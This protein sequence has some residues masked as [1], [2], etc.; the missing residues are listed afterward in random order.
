L[1]GVLTHVQGDQLFGHT[2]GHSGR[3]VPLT[4]PALQVYI[5]EES[6]PP[7][8]EVLSPD[9]LFVHVARQACEAWAGTWAPDSGVLTG[10]AAYD[11]WQDTLRSAPAANAGKSPLRV[12]HSHA[13]RLLLAARCCLAAWLRRVPGKQRELAARWADTCD[14]VAQL[15]RPYES[16]EAVR[17]VLAQPDGIQHVCRALENACALEAKVVKQLESDR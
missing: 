8:P 14:R 3:P 11:A 12:Q 5:V 10:P 15:L 2:P 1:W 17:A 16:P 9:V 6:Q 13:T 7:I 4:G